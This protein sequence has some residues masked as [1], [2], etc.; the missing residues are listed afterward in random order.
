M[1]CMRKCI[2][3]VDTFDGGLWRI[4]VN[5]LEVSH[6]I[7]DVKRYGLRINEGNAFVHYPPHRIG[8]VA[9]HIHLPG[10]T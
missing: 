6:Y 7:E 2:V 4:Y 10:A 5:E 3:Q 1:V 8:N 9:I